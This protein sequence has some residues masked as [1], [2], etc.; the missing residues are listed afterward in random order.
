VGERRSQGAGALAVD[1]GQMV[2]GAAP[3]PGG[4]EPGDDVG[5][6]VHG[7]DSGSDLLGRAL[8]SVHGHAASCTVRAEQLH[9]RQM[10][11][12]CCHKY[13]RGTILHCLVHR[14]ARC[15][16]ARHGL[17]VAVLARQEQG[18]ATILLCLIDRCACCNQ[19]RDRLRVAVLARDDQGRD[20]I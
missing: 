1:D 8:D 14:R 3:Q 11:V 9:A 7:R 17:R 10:A 4:G 18:R 12:G 2:E 5:V 13:G 16:Q 20:T 15:K 6:A 19:P